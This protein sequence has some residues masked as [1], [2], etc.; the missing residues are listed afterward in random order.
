MIHLKYADILKLNREFGERISGVPYQIK[1]I[2]NITTNQVNDILELSLRSHGINAVAHSGEYDNI[3][4]ESTRLQN[5]NLVV[6]FW[7][8]ANLIDGFHYK[9]PLMEEDALE[10][11]LSKVEEEISFVFQNLGSHPFVLFNRFSSLAH[12]YYNIHNNVL[13]RV[14]QRLN[15]FLNKNCPANVTLVD[16]DKVLVQVSVLRGVDWRSYCS[17]RA[18][19]SIEYF[20]AYVSQISPLILGVLG[21]SKK[22]LIFD[23]DNTLWKGIVGEDGISGIEMTTETPQGMYF[24]EVQHL[25]LELHQQG[26]IL[27]LCSKNN[28]EDV[29]EVLAHH[30][31]MHVRNENLV[32]KKVNWNDKASNLL[33]IAEEL[34]IG[35]DSLV[36]VEDSDFEVQL[37]REKLP[38]VTVLQ[39][40]KR[41]EDYP[42]MIR[43]HMNLFHTSILG[44][45]DLQRA[46]M[47]KQEALRKSEKKNY[48]TIEDY[49]R[50]LNLRMRIFVNSMDLAPRIAQLTQKTNQF[51][52]TTKRYTEV[53]I[54]NFMKNGSDVFAIEVFDKFGDY[55]V[56]GVCVLT[57][58]AGE[59]RGEFDTLLMSCRVLG[60]N[61]EHCFLNVLM[62]H[63]RARG[64]I[65]V[66]S[67]YIS[68]TKNS[69]V[70]CFFDDFGFRVMEQ[71]ESSKSYFII[72]G[73]YRTNLVEYIGVEYG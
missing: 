62:E 35:V 44:K 52:L 68:T 70:E 24:E 63:L 53:E 25:A 69:Q 38:Q 46:A 26:I 10:Q 36:F 60:R 16:T 13:D 31:G 14:T 34:N 61:I 33:A 50:G 57:Y 40:P 27:G 73:D 2:S 15:A 3:V 56:T 72:P 32:I 12:T 18:L 51:N 4:Q 7:E 43:E 65:E 37:V 28:A 11:L 67:L 59:Q 54:R 64:V 22:A 9:A 19:Y 6:I 66:R 39:V 23:C 20:K 55:G 71:N 8:L 58:S 45:E 42:R 48:S 1:V 30:P 47:Y 21:K 5:S 49:L 17:S 29:D 41:L